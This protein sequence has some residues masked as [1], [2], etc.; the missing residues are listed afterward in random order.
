MVLL[1]DNVDL[2]ILATPGYDPEAKSITWNNGEWE[3]YC[4]LHKEEGKL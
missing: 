4:E 3:N 2:D 1:L